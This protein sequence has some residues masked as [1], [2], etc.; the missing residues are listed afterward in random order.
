[1][2]VRNANTSTNRW[3]SIYAPSTPPALHGKEVYNSLVIS[4]LPLFV[5][6][7]RTNK[8]QVCNQSSDGDLHLTGIF[9]QPADAAMHQVAH[10]L[11]VDAHDAADVLILA[12]LYIIEVDNLTLAR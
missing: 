8:E 7:L 10:A 12:V 11:V 9:S 6:S 1:M 2:F 4:C 5:F 3:Q